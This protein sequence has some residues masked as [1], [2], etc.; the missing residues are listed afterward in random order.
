MTT[1]ANAAEMPAKAADLVRVL[2]PQPVSALSDRGEA[3]GC[4]SPP[5][6]RGCAE[7]SFNKRVRRQEL[8]RLVSAVVGLA[9]IRP[10]SSEVQR[11]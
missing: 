5:S 9:A 1:F 4:G 7:S 11:Q 2:P 8:A 10:I 3:G 6:R